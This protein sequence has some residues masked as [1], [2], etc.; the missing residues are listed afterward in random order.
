[1]HLYIFKVR[2]KEHTTL[3]AGFTDKEYRFCNLL[4]TFDSPKECRKC[5]ALYSRQILYQSQYNFHNFMI[6]L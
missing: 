1:M 4:F 6:G 3:R 2:P 5:A